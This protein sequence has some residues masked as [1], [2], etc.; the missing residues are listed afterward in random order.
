M[1][2]NAGSP[3]IHKA[4]EGSHEGFPGHCTICGQRV[5]QVPGGQGMTWV[6]S[7]SGAVAAPNPP[8]YQP[9]GTWELRLDEHGGYLS[10]GTEAHVKAAAQERIALAH[11]LHNRHEE[12][13][14]RSDMY[15][16]KPDGTHQGQ[17]YDEAGFVPGEAI[18]WI[19]VDW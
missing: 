7:D 9:G 3:G 11:H 12:A 6:H 14:L 15:L 4:E 13:E 18:Q 16:V 10:T 19:D 1:T 17:R 8:C 5:R 2:D